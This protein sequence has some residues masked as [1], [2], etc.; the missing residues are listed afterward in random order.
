MLKKVVGWLV[1]IFLVL[2]IASNP[3]GAAR[4]TR[5]LGADLSH[6]ASGFGDFFSRLVG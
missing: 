1:V 6:I 5:S 4:M 2:F 3:A